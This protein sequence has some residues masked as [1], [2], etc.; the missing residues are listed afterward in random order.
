VTATRRTG[1]DVLLVRY[2]L[3]KSNIMAGLTGAEQEVLRHALCGMQPAQIAATR[4]TSLN[5]VNN[6]LR[7][8]YKKLGVRSASE[9]AARCFAD[10]EA[11]RET[12]QLELR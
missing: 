5:T 6:Q 8:I 1:K 7:S 3:P 11:V 2:S 12:L 10:S 9:L 4:R